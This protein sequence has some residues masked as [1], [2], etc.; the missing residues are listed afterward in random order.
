M[1]WAGFLTID[2]VTSPLPVFTGFNWGQLVA[3]GLVYVLY[4]FNSMTRA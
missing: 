3:V 4:L 1:G 2:S